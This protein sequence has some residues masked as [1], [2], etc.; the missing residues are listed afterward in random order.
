MSKRQSEMERVKESALRL[1]PEELQLLLRQ[2]AASM[3]NIVIV[4]EGKRAPIYRRPTY[5]WGSRLSAMR[6]IFEGNKKEATPKTSSSS[7]HWGKDLVAL[8]DTLDFG[9][10]SDVD[11]P[12]ESLKQQREQERMQRLGDWGDEA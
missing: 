7:G 9:D 8:V 2:L 1:K 10:W 4:K 12:V 3:G 11:D 6:S 5:S